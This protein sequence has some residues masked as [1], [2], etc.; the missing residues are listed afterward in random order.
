MFVTNHEQAYAI[1][2]IY[3]HLAILK[4]VKTRFATHFIVLTRLCAVKE[5]LGSMVF[6]KAWI[7]W[8]ASNYEKT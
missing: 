1:F 4:V 5:A 7:E 3:S 6:S 2:K 8:R